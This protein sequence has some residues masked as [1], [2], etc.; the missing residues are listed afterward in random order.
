[1]QYTM[2]GG[3]VGLGGVVHLTAARAA[4]PDAPI[5]LYPRASGTSGGANLHEKTRA[6][7]EKVYEMVGEYPCWAL[8]GVEAGHFLYPRPLLELAA[9]EARRS[10]GILVAPT[11]NRFVRWRES[12]KVDYITQRRR[13]FSVP[14]SEEDFAALR[15]LTD[16]VVL[17]TLLHPRATEAEQHSFLTKLTGRAGRP[18]RRKPKRR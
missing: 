13:R 15:Q 11:L 18:E 12:Y 9:A 5:I 16:G 14:P 17:A 1:M 8:G 3:A 4:R 6:A 7:A 2:P 10:G